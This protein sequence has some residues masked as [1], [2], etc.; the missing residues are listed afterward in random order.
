MPGRSP[1]KPDPAPSPAN[2]EQLIL[3]LLSQRS[4]Q[5]SICPSDAARAARPDG[6]RALM[7]DVRG[8]AA[9]LA[10]RGEVDVTQ[11]GRVV[12]IATA[13]GPVRIRRHQSQDRSE[14]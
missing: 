12:D 8:A 9:R 7:D 10:A 5:S 2:L 3:R 4:P 11:R 6:W 14:Q 1:R 13:R